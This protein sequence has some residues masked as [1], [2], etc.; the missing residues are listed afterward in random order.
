MLVDFQFW[1][2]PQGGRSPIHHKVWF[3][4]TLHKKTSVTY[5]YFSLPKTENWSWLDA[6]KIK[7]KNKMWVTNK[8]PG[9]FQDFQV[10]QGQ[11][12]IP[13]SLGCEPWEEA[14]DK[15]QRTKMFQDHQVSTNSTAAKL[16]Q[17]TPHMCVRQN[18]AFFGSME[19]FCWVV[20]T[21]RRW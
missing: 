12:K 18:C 9:P 2:R 20:W 15:D 6:C 8:V 13:R 17:W 10:F 11:L 7:L 14:C 1:N 16:R 3:N 19:S 21:Q 5:E 4:K